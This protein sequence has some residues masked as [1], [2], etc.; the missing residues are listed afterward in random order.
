MECFVERTHST[1]RSTPRTRPQAASRSTTTGTLKPLVNALHLVGDR[2][3]V[4]TIRGWNARSFGA[5]LPVVSTRLATPDMHAHVTLRVAYSLAYTR[6]RTDSPDPTR[7][8]EQGL[9]AIHR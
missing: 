1:N 5:V 3:R 7:R 6:D 4:A 2:R 8:T 9:N